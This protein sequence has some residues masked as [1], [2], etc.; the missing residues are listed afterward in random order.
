MLTSPLHYG[1][2]IVAR[3]EDRKMLAHPLLS[4]AVVS[5]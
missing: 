1:Q 4:M 2:L 3:Y 5:L